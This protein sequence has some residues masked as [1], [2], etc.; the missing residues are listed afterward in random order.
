MR[1]KNQIVL[2]VQIYNIYIST[3]LY[4]VFNMF[5]QD[6]DGVIG[7]EDLKEINASLGQLNKNDFILIRFKFYLL[8]TISYK[9]S[10]LGVWFLIFQL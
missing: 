10:Y 8:D 9:S 2:Y 3:K 1:F 6:R 4:Q 7:L 5:D